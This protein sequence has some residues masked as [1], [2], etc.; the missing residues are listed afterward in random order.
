MVQWWHGRSLPMAGVASV[1]VA[2]EARGRGVGGALMSTLV[3][4]IAAR[5]Y[6]LSVLYPATAAVYRGAGYE[7]AG[8]QYQVSIPARSLRSL[9]PP[10]VTGR[11]ARAASRARHPAGGASRCR[12]DQRGPGPGA[13]GGPRLRPVRF[14]PERVRADA[15]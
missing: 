12:R 10:D 8:G 15:R 13:R 2:P 9:L 7:I 1:T 11:P 4:Q 6:P 14:R 3:R 5:G